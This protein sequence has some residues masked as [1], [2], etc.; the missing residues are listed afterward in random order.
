MTSTVHITHATSGRALQQS[1]EGTAEGPAQ[2]QCSARIGSPSEDT[3]YALTPRPLYSSAPPKGTHKPKNQGVEA[4]VVHLPSPPVTQKGQFCFP[5]PQHWLCREIGLGPWGAH[6][7]WGTIARVSLNYKHDRFQGSQGEESPSW[8]DHQAEV[9]LLLH[10]GSRR[11]CAPLVT[12]SSPHL[13]V[14]CLHLTVH[15]QG[16]KTQLERSIVI[17]TLEHS[18]LRV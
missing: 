9:R 8:P 4:R 6:L 14:L 15:G 16:Q 10:K 18:A 5:C 12:H 2:K 3:G 13:C 1:A 11:R 7:H 17:R